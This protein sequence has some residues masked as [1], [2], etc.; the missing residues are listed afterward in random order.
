M[1]M[2]LTDATNRLAEIEKYA[3]EHLQ[4][5]DDLI[6]LLD[7][8]R[9]QDERIAVLEKVAEAGRDL[10][11]YGNIDGDAS[12]QINAREVKRLLEA[13]REAGYE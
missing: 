12:V 13:L 8:V 11:I 9:K 5:D 7:L 2:S 6:W 4:P 10:D 3:R 1:S